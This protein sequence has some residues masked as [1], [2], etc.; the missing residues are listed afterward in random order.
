MLNTSFIFNIPTRI[1][2]GP[3]RFQSIGGSARSFGEKALVVST[4]GESLIDLQKECRS[5]L[6]ANGVQSVLF[7]RVST[8]PSHTL[9]DE[10]CELAIN[11]KC[12][13]VIG[14]GG[15]SAM[16]VAK[17]VA[18]AAVEHVRAWDIVEGGK[19]SHKP[20]PVIAVP[21]TSGTGSEV[22]QYAV[23]S[24]PEKKMK[25]GIGRREFYPVLSI[26]DPVLTMSMPAD[27]TAAVG[28]DA[29]THAIEGYTTVHS[30]PLTDSLA[31]T[32]IG[33]IGKSLRQ[34]VF[35][36]GD[37]GARS[38]MMLASMLAGIAITHADTSLAHV[39]GEA[40]GAVF[41]VHHGLAVALTLPAVM[42]FNCFTS[43]EKFGRI[44]ELLGERV[45]GL[46]L[47]DSAKLAPSAVRSLIYDIGVPRGLAAL[48]VM[49]D[50]RVMELCTRPGSD[51]A[52]PR[53]ASERDFSL[54]I[55]GSL[56]DKMSY[57]S[58][59]S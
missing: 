31:E 30:N 7:N 4:A 49:K 23:V 54:I 15:G 9:I 35:H 32:A 33:L 58:L 28:L 17:T 56:S 38:D 2:Y 18:V 37:L 11:E 47:R 51:G 27:L 36:P 59:L 19:L 46:S 6:E 50:K 29:L 44:A 12:D 8:N 34:A 52:N 3:N 22:T 5:L 43:V 53:S 21:T 24:N 1:E 40:A 20:I 39:V 42:E 13:L 25:E 45:T 55:D 57:W 10:A 48:G 26:V 16:D 14:L 41:S